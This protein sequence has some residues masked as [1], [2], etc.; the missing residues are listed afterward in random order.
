MTVR[1]DPLVNAEL[2][3]GA[4]NDFDGV[5]PLSLTSDFGANVGTNFGDVAQ[6][7]SMGM[8]LG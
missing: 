4:A 5:E 1:L 3:M 6:T 8:N 2:N 7:I